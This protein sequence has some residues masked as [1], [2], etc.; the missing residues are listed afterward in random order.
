MDFGS[1]VPY[2]A[3]AVILLGTLASGPLA[4]ADRPADQT[5]EVGAG[6]VTVSEVTLPE[7]ADLRQGRYGED[8]FYL[9]VPDAT[10]RF[11]G[12]AG[13]PVLTYKLEIPD[14]GY[15]RET[16]FFLGPDTGDR[17][18]LSLERDQ[19]APDRIENDSYAGTL[20]VV[21]RAGNESRVVAKRNIT[22]EVRR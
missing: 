11:E 14:L 1:S 12:V 16:A 2:V 8:S 21:E 19:I 13:R 20:R 3:A 10:I 5:T 15:S 9:R 7:S 22:V 6:S 4:L 17:M 18:E